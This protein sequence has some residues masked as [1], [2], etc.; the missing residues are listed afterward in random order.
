MD[1]RPQ[2]QSFPFFFFPSSCVEGTYVW[3]WKLLANI[4]GG[5]TNLIKETNFTSLFLELDW[6]SNTVIYNFHFSFTG[7][8][9]IFKFWDKLNSTP[10]FP[11]LIPKYSLVRLGFLSTPFHIN[12]LANDF[13]SAYSFTTNNF[14]YIKQCKSNIC[15][16]HHSVREVG[17][18]VVVSSQFLG[19]VLRMC[20]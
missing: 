16:D 6:I 2:A 18:F 8:C 12:I 20:I 13:I 5:A 19:S 15:S 1:C 3:R 9:P 11:L 4:V 7:G 10:C 14:I 17:T